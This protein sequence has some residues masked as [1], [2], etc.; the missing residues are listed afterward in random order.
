MRN[1]WQVAEMALR[2]VKRSARGRVFGPVVPAKKRSKFDPK[3]FLSTID[4][5]GKIATFPKKQTIFG[6]G[7]SSDAVFYIQKGKGETHRCV[8]ER[9]GSHD[10][11]SV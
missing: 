6:Q 11:H 8:E 5:G 7:D 9:E 1:I 4:G 10:R 2:I 3:T